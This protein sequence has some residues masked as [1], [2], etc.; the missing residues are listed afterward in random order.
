MNMEVP[1]GAGGLGS[2]AHDLL[3]WARALPVLEVVGD[4]SFAR[5]TAPTQLG[6]DVVEYGLG[7]QRG[8]HGAVPWYG[9]GGKIDGFNIWIEWLPEQDAA[10]VVLV[11][12]EG[13]HAQRLR[14]QLVPYLVPDAKA[15]VAANG[16]APGAAKGGG[17]AASLDATRAAQCLGR[18]V[19]GETVVTIARASGG[20]DTSEPARLTA[21]L[22][23]QSPVPLRFRGERNGRL[24]FEIEPDPTQ[25]LLF[26]PEASPSRATMTRP[27]GL[28]RL[29]RAEK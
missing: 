7:L 25:H 21:Q 27:L 19:G 28:R 2:T 29:L 17:T 22:G 5:M 1:R 23:G 15:A 18:Y 13:S 26:E 10:L 20:S 14:E 16:A 9:H 4:E 11:N 3:F 12:T 24:D 8:H 6:D